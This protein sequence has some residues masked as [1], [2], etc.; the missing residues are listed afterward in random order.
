MGQ[1]QTNTPITDSAMAMGQGQT[2]PSLTVPWPWDKQT[3]PSLTGPWP[4]DREMPRLS[5]GTLAAV[6]FLFWDGGGRWQPLHYHHPFTVVGVGGG[7]GGGCHTTTTTH[8]L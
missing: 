4:W 6:I 5:F 8:L 1:G 3:H 7:G 2:N